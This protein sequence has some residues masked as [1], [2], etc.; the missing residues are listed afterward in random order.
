M[1]RFGAINLSKNH[2]ILGKGNIGAKNSIAAL[3]FF[4]KKIMLPGSPQNVNDQYRKLKKR[5]IKR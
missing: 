4:M 1:L 5:T 3:L 2:S